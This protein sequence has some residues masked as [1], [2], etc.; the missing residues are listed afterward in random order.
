MER[1]RLALVWHMHQP[2]YRDA[3]SGEHLLPWTRLHATKDYGDMAALLG[4]YPAVHA[5]FN[6]TPVLLDQ[7]E[8][9]AS[10][11]V[12]RWL[13]VARK[14]AE[15]LSQAEREF[16][17]TRFFDVHR[18]R[19]LETSPPYRDLERQAREALAR[20]SGRSAGVALLRDLSVWFHLAW[21]DPGYRD[22]EPVRSLLRK[23]SGFSEGEK[24]SLLDWGVALAGGIVAQ[25]RALQSAGQVE[26]ITSAHHHPILPLVIDTDAPREVSAGIPLPSPAFR[27]PQDAAI[28][29]RRARES[30]ARRFGAEPRGT[31]PPEGAVS[32]ATLALLASEGLQ[33]AASDETVLAAALEAR[34]GALRDWPA[35]LYRPYRVDTRSGSIDLVFRDRRLSDLI[36]F[37]YGHWD[38]DE[39]ARDFLRQVQMAGMMAVAGG[40]APRLDGAPLVT[41]ILDG[42]N[43]WE[44]YAEDG[45]PF[46]NALYGRLS[47]EPGIRTVTVREALDERPPSE[48]LAHVPVGSWI[49]QDLGI[50][51][52]HPDKNRAW[53]E[54]GRARAAIE[55]ASRRSGND[56][57]ATAAAM[58]SIYAAEGSDWYWWYGDDHPSAHRDELDRLF[59]TR[60][61]AAYRSLGL[62]EPETLR[63]SLRE[64]AGAARPGGWPAGER[65]PLVRPR[66]DGAVTDFFEWRDAMSYDAGAGSGAMHRVDSR[67]RTVHWGTDGMALHLRVDWSAEGPGNGLGGDEGIEIAFE[68]DPGRIARIAAQ[69]TGESGQGVPQWTGAGEPDGANRP[70]GIYAIGR[71]VEISLP[72][73]RCG[74]APGASLRFRVSIA[75]DGR[76]VEQLPVSAWLRLTVPL[77]PLDL[78]AWSTL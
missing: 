43:C 19:M 76:V 5:T 24:T 31:W 7:L 51:V 67:L 11:A 73:D 61:I 28:Q 58:E 34:D 39:A 49:R 69:G 62:E 26:L 20:D 35:A 45:H 77:A 56:R 32:D 4:R 55:R 54:L 1:T 46:L 37:T 27:A 2:S 78:V 60:L 66:V 74:A 75:R 44:H 41:V 3:L 42:E 21:V 6:L 52:G 65:I 14:P 8:E 57:A 70:A 53:E 9:I 12:D 71:V 33:W 59:R 36:G 18:E 47:A 25:Y 40:E 23:G 48:R 13:E 15:S 17:L 68:G 50:W 38:P 10:G 22:E 72:L 16:L 64:D 29:V 30:H 63:T